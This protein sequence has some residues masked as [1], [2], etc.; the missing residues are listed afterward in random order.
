M[1]AVFTV[2]TKKL[3]LRIEWL[4][5]CSSFFSAFISIGW[6]FCSFWKCEL[7]CCFWPTAICVGVQTKHRKMRVKFSY[8]SQQLSIKHYK[9]FHAPAVS[10]AHS[11]CNSDKCLG[12]LFQN[13]MDYEY[14]GAPYIWNEK[15][16]WRHVLQAIRI[17][18]ILKIQ[19]PRNSNNILIFV[20]RNHLF[21]TM[22]CGQH[23]NDTFRQKRFFGNYQK[24]TFWY[25]GVLY[26]VSTRPFLNAFPF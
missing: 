23:Q 11:L 18:R 14:F 20:E 8:R 5:I 24:Q 10:Y 6:F 16:R 4:A 12:Y 17:R 1:L 21:L 9:W 19:T 3:L 22:I 2:R 7:N 13:S 25:E 26:Y 15:C